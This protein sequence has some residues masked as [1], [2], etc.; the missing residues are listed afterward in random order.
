MSQISWLDEEL[1]SFPSTKKALDSPNGLLAAGGDLRPERLISAYAR[2]IFPW[3]SD[4]QPILWW[5]PDPRMI[6]APADIHI[7]RSLRKRVRK[8]TYEITVDQAFHE[9]VEN[10]AATPRERENGTWITAEMRH[11]YIAL[12]HYGAA[13]SVEAWDDTGKLVG[14]LYGVALGKAFFGESMFS[15]ASDASKVAFVTLV[16]QLQKWDFQLIDC[17]VQTDYLASF[18][19]TEVSRDVF[20]KEIKAAVTP[21]DLESFHS[22]SESWTMPSYGPTDF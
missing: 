9:V 15:H 14:G 4:G 16:T 13:H 7:G 17:Q 18:G 11:A 10:C 20:E 6:L 22:W 2:G 19:A 1:L 5:S 12:H 21:E 3:Y 8:K